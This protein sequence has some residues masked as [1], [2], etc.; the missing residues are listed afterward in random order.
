MTATTKPYATGFQHMRQ[1]IRQLGMTCTKTP[2]DEYRVTFQPEAFH[3]DLK[4]YQQLDQ[5][6]GAVPTAPEIQDRQEAVAY[7]TN[8]LLDAYGTAKLMR[9]QLHETGYGFDNYQGDD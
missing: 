1:R 8:D 5:W 4:L 9:A 6:I 7:Y 3:L 2:Y